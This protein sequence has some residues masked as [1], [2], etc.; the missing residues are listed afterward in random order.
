MSSRIKLT[1]SL[2]PVLCEYTN[3]QITCQVHLSS[4]INSTR[5]IMTD[6]KIEFGLI[7]DLVKKNG[8]SWKIQK[9]VEGLNEV[10][11]KERMESQGLGEGLW[12]QR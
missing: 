6:T 4:K 8:R 2:T 10:K 7:T 12:I 11:C 3:T 5:L 1:N 9:R